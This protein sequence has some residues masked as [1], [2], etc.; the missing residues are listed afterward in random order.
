M[1]DTLEKQYKDKLGID[2]YDAIVK[3]YSQQYAYQAAMKVGS[4]IMQS[5]LFD[6]VR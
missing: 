6:Y 1:K 3:M 2:P 4:N 5:S